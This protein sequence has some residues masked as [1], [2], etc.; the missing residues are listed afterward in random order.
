M[1]N[2]AAPAFL[3]SHDIR[4]V[5]AGGVGTEAATETFHVCGVNY[6]RKWRSALAL[7][8]RV[9]LRN[10]C[11]AVCVTRTTLLLESIVAVFSVA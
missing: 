2:A 7:N 9:H 10:R 4:H 1:G 3:L 11:R 8:R 6:L 5:S